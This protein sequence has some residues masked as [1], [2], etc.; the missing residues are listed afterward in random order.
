MDNGK[1][2]TQSSWEPNLLF[3]RAS[4]RRRTNQNKTKE[5]EA[6][7]PPPQ[8]GVDENT[9]LEGSE[10]LLRR[11]KNWLNFTV[12]L[13]ERPWLSTLGIH[14]SW[15]GSPWDQGLVV[16][17]PEKKD[18]A[19]SAVGMNGAVQDETLLQLTVPVMFV[20]GSKDGLCPLEQLEAVRKKMNSITA[21]HVIEG[22]E[23]SFSISKKHLQ[24]TGSNQEEAE[25]QAVQAIMAFVS[26]YLRER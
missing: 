13:S 14:L 20:Q 3:C 23:N 10:G 15:L 11:P 22:G 2:H 21:L 4:K 16:W 19:A 9:L 25:D 1:R 5:E 18:I 12:T 17:L 8:G 24:S 7:K 6:E 26:S